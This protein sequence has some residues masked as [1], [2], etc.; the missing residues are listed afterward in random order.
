MRNLRVLCLCCPLMLAMTLTATAEIK[1]TGGQT[2]ETSESNVKHTIAGKNYTCD[3]CV[4]STCDSAGG[5]LTN[6][7]R[8]TEWSNCVAAAGGNTG[9]VD[10]TKVDR[11][12]VPIS[13]P[14]K[15][16]QQVAPPKKQ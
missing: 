1:G 10:R 2:C 14:P 13:P 16:P 8:V 6:C 5:T 4:Y 3:K 12:S 11:I 9:G 15:G 7:K